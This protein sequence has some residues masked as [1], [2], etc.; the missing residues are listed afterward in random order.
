MFGSTLVRIV[1]TRPQRWLKYKLRNI[2]IMITA[3]YHTRCDSQLLHLAS[4]VSL[5]SDNTIHFFVIDYL[6]PRTP[7][8][9]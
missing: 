2:S 7:L 1:Q 6:Q 9:V 3:T 4:V 8:Y 5:A